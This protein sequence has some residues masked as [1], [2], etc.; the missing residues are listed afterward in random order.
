[1][2]LF[3]NP[4]ESH[5]HSL[6]VLNALVEYDSFLDSLKVIADMGCGAGLDTEWWAKL[7]T[8]DEPKEPRNYTVYA[9]DKNIKLLDPNIKKLKNVVALGG[10]FTERIIP[11]K[12]DLIWAHNV[13]QGV[14]DPFKCLAAWKETMSVNGMLV[15]SIPQS[16]YFDARANKLLITSH[17]HQYYSYN[18]LSLMYML[19]VSGFDTRDAY[20]YRE[21]GTPWLYAAVYASEHG[22]L[23][24][25]TTWH[26]LAERKLINDSV[27]TSLNRYGYAR[28]DEVAVMWLDKNLY[29][30][31]D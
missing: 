28:L 23:D 20:F 1:M 12:V 22:V 3:R 27:M 8:R 7:E 29:I 26:E 13:F 5:E 16:T 4:K 11:R 25:Q 10:D 21:P 19:A 15:L 2:G 18:I 30:V 24:R 31:T 9:V 6:R 17:D 14:M